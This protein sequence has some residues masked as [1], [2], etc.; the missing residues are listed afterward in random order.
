MVFMGMKKQ[1]KVLHVFNGSFVS[2]PEVSTIPGLALL[3]TKNLAEC[4]ALFLEEMRLEGKARTACRSYANSFGL[5]TFGID[6]KS[7]FDLS[8]IIRL[9]KIIRE[10]KYSHVHGQDVKASVYLALATL[11]LSVK[12]MT[13]F[14][15][16]VRVGLRD[17]IYEWLYF[18]CVTFF[19]HLISISQENY[20][21]L[22]TTYF[23]FNDNMTLIEN[24]I[25]RPPQKSMN[26]I[27][28]TLAKIA[29]LPPKPWGIM[30]ARFS[31]EKNH[32]TL[33]SALRRLS[34]HEPLVVWFFG[35]G[36]LEEQL[37]KAAK[38]LGVENRVIFGGQLPEGSSYLSAFDYFFLVSEKEGLPMSLLEA[39]SMG[40]TII[41]SDIPGI[42]K[43]IS[44]IEYGFLS[45]PMDV[46]ELALNIKLALSL[47]LSQKIQRGESL[48]LHIHQKYSLNDWAA[49]LLNVYQESAS[50]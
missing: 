7:R 8:A 15:G 44:N 47:P 16:F 28:T 36:P 31:P 40:L 32:I 35:F 38:D 30:L 24:A 20:E 3:T 29:P 23:W 5:T 2:G 42:K 34:I 10:E 37:K 27:E 18:F 4:H 19:D 46:E 25:S 6:V 50:S 45:D 48:K 17:K 33:L 9:R 21:R 14:H 11:G 22:K 49:K 26:E 41:G 13:T 1:L 39:A 43:V 12:K